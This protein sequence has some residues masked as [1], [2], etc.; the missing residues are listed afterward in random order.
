MRKVVSTFLMVF[1]AT[2]L[3]TASPH[4]LVNVDFQDA[5]LV[6]VLKFVAKEMGRNCYIGPE[7]RG[8][9]NLKADGIPLEQVLKRALAQQST[10]YDYKLVGTN[11]LVVATGEKLAEIQDP[12]LSVPAGQ[13]RSAIAV[14]AD[15]LTLSAPS[16]A[17]PPPAPPAN[18]PVDYNT[19]SYD[20][21]SETGYRE[22]SKEPLSTFSIDVDT[23]SYSNVRRFLK[24]GEMPPKD[25]V[26][27]E[28]LINY[29][30]YQFGRPK[31]DDPFTVTT[32]LADC[33]WNNGHQLLQVALAAPALQSEETPPRNLVFLLDV[34]GSMSSPDK[35]PLL[36]KGLELL[37]STL[38]PEDH[39]SIVVYAGASGTVLGPTPGDQKVTILNALGRL[40]AGG[41]TN[42]GAGIELAYALASEN[43]QKDAI[44]RVILA[45]DGDFNVGIASRGAL[46][47]LIEKKRES[48]IFLTVLGF[49]TGNLKDSN[50]EQLADKGNGNYA[51]IDNLME[52]K[53]V[54]VD[55]A[56]STLI[57]V[58]KDVK[59]QLEFNPL[60]VA[61]YRLIGYENRRL[62]NEDFQDDKKD[63]GEIGAGHTVTALYEIV[64][65]QSQAANLRYQQ[66]AAPSDKARS[67]ETALVKVRYKEPDGQKSKLLEIV[68]DDRPAPFVEASE[69]LRFASSV[70]AVGMLLQDSE[71][72]GTASYEEA[73]GWARE[74]LGED[75]YGYRRE[76]VR[77]VELAQILAKPVR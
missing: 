53:K 56:S 70:A 62:N 9:V 31:G 34:S 36:L 51:Y 75:G 49:G 40:S 27:I 25:A 42:G 29:F 10:A 57:T 16:P 11:T 24:T 76:F 21:I 41:S 67:N 73:L 46:I 19:E 15:P 22:V 69:N 45:S 35:L 38:R 17:P 66:E 5:D 74:A 71:F 47:E 20:S 12:I 48:G 55:E 1:L 54:L 50:M 4:K 63:A 65:G 59:L 58:A 18:A 30:S 7:V 28:E 37:V 60:K 26:R 2:A 14:G 61:S 77:L 44:N 33:P 32:E 72:K 8:K 64:P 39:V 3:S 13:L 43:F 23:G 68:V 6:Q 52:A